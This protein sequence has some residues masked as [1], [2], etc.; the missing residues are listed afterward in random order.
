MKTLE[1]RINRL[2]H[3]NRAL[4]TTIGVLLL[5]LIFVGATRQDHNFGNITVRSL[6]VISKDGQVTGILSS[7]G[8]LSLGEPN[9]YTKIDQLG[10][11]ITNP[12]TESAT[13]TR[14]GL[15]IKSKIGKTETQILSSGTII[16]T[17]DKSTHILPGSMVL[18]ADNQRNVITHLE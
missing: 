11:T 8:T 4:F 16:K 14:F 5:L 10:I 6:K 17:P 1:Q 18:S 12:Q 3:N 15:K 13:L 2:E 7:N 9:I